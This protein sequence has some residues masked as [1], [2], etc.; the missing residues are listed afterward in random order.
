[1]YSPEERA[2]LRQ[3]YLDRKEVF[4]GPVDHEHV[5]Q[6]IF[7]LIDMAKN[8]NYINMVFCSPGGETNAGFRLAQFIEQEID[9]PVNARVWGQCSSAAT[10]PLLCCKKRVAHPQ[11]TFVLHRQTAGIELEYNLDFK[12]RVHEW[13]QDNAKTHTRQVDFYSRKLKLN[14]EQVEEELLR[15]TGIDA[16]IMV[17]RA[18]QIG[19]ITA[20]SKFP[21]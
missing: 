16:E 17:E 20:V 2:T 21:S 3:Y 4:L 18:K 15:G 13:V 8:S 6:V 10:Y 7:D 14:K 19:L 9:V 12:E 11:T 5:N 1:M